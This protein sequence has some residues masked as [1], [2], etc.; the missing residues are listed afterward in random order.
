MTPDHDC[1]ILWASIFP[2]SCHTAPS[3]RK[4]VFPPRIQKS[5]NMLY[6]PTTSILLDSESFL[7]QGIPL[8]I[9]CLHYYHNL[10]QVLCHISGQLRKGQNSYGSLSGWQDGYEDDAT[11]KRD[12]TKLL[13]KTLFLFA[14]LTSRSRLEYLSVLPFLDP[15]SSTSLHCLAPLYLQH[16]LV[17]LLYSLEFFPWVAPLTQSHSYLL[18]TVN[19]PR[20]A[21]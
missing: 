4:K 8:S 15:P 19:N 13:N 2:K 11:T 17:E 9:Q 10:S 21:S 18:T 6:E 12:I 5:L 7:K 16:S 3:K 14:I 1:L 20:G